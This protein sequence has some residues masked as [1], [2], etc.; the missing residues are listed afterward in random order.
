MKKIGRLVIDIQFL[1]TGAYDRGMGRYFVGL[2]REILLKIDKETEVYC[3][4]TTHFEE[5]NINKFRQELE[6]IK[7][8]Q[9]IK[10][11]ALDFSVHAFE[12][13]NYLQAYDHNVDVANSFLDG[14]SSEPTLWFVPSLMQEPVVPVLPVRKN[15]ET[16][17]LWHD[18]M[19]YLMHDHYFSEGSDT[20][21][22]KSYLRRLTLLLTTDIIVTN[23]ETTRNDLVKFLSLPPQRVVNINGSVNAQ[24]VESNPVPSK[25]I[26]EPFFL[27]PASPEPNKNVLRTLEAFELFS[28]QHAGYR[29]VVTSSYN[30]QIAKQAA[31]RG[32][33][34]TFTGHISNPEL[35]GLYQ[36]A[37]GLLFMSTYE[38]LGM[39][40]LEAVAFNK[41]VICSN[42]SVFREI[43]DDNTFYFADPYDSK[44]IARALETATDAKQRNLKTAYEAIRKKYTWESSAK[45]FI[46]AVTMGSPLQKTA[47][48]KLAVVGPHPSSFSSIGK[49]V[50][51]TIPLLS[52]TTEAHYYFDSGPSDQRHGLVRFSYL[53]QYPYL[54]SISELPSRATDYE[55]II[56]HMGNS[57]HHMKSYLLAHAL[58]GTVVLH[59]TDLSGEGLAGQ[60][61]SNGYLSQE[62]I[63]LEYK[64]ESEYLKKPERFITSLLSAQHRVITHSTF[65]SEVAKDY[66]LGKASMISSYHPMQALDFPKFYREKSLDEP[67]RLGIA[68]IMT[69]VKGTD[70]IQWLLEQ[71]DGLEGCHLT[72]FGFGF[73][74]DKDHLLRL[75]AEYSNIEVTFDLTDFA[76]AN[77][78][79]SMDLL[80]NYRPVYK[81]EASRATLE[82][83][84]EGVVPIVRNIGWYG[85][86]PDE[87]GYKLDNIEELADLVNRLKSDVRQARHE[88]SGKRSAGQELLR[89]EYGFEPYTKHLLGNGVR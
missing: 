31:R 40:L 66:C 41:K 49:F 38:G 43:G 48:T 74:A 71:T 57:D 65:A 53:Q 44:D 16:S 55:Q 24:I 83:L 45:A 20:A 42:I 52:E 87:V 73:F 27:C 70:A 7:E 69:S 5:A 28:R 22:A 85:E 76:F 62:R 84:R 61:L 36:H 47:K 17:V 59:D 89:K 33:K 4:Y 3:L 19:P 11:E 37:E 81:G 46:A 14:L 26:Q 12:Q 23:S 64:V 63:G 6:G 13:D 80:V 25:N 34:V 77:V 29:L 30:E 79:A 50:A 67:L 21:H 9:R 86:L 10:L 56:Y 82:A 75:A 15:I 78:L 51:E 1:Q 72:V 54:Y 35:A 68:G 8:G 2:L 39:P 18:L 60:M 88:L 58:P 32:I